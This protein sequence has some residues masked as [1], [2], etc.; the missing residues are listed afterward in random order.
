VWAHSPYLDRKFSA[1]AA[2]R[3][4]FGITRE[5]LKNPPPGAAQML[6]GVRPVL[7]R[8]VSS[9][10]CAVPFDDGRWRIS[11]TGWKP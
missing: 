1:L 3:S 5:M 8:E 2:H 4:A 11:L 9:E 10:V 6:P 7:E